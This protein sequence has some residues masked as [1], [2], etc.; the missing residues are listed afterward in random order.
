MFIDIY[1]RIKFPDVTRRIIDNNMLSQ[2]HN[3]LLHVAVLIEDNY[4]QKIITPIIHLSLHITHCCEDYGLL[5]S[6]WCYSFERINGLLG[7]KLINYTDLCE[8]MLKY[9]LLFL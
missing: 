9:F 7:N 3:R 8:N 4:G 1:P 5:Y 2:T 6:F